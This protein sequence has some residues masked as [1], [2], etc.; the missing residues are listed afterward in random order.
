[1]STEDGYDAEPQFEQTPPEDG[2][3]VPGGADE[4]QYETL[5]RNYCRKNEYDPGEKQE[6]PWTENRR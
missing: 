4:G 1:M 6:Q 2:H 5:R 3:R